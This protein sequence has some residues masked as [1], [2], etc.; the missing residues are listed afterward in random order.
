MGLLN[1][2]LDSDHFHIYRKEIKRLKYLKEAKNKSEIDR[3]ADDGEKTGVFTGSYAV[4]PFSNKK[5]QIWI[6]DYVIGSYGTGAIMAVPG[7]DLRDFEF[8]TKYNLPIVEVVSED[9]TINGRGECFTDYG[10]SVNS[11]QYN[12]LKSAELIKI[13]SKEL[14]QMG[15]GKPT[16]Q[17]RLHDWLISRQRYWGSPIPIIHCQD[18]GPIPVPEKDLPVL[19]P[20]DIEFSSTYGEDISPLATVNS[21]INTLCPEC[22]NS[23]KRDC[24]TMDTFVCSSWYYLRYPNAKYNDGPFDPK[25]LEWLPVDTYVGGA[26]HATMHLL[27][28][29]FIT[30]VLRDLG[31]LYFDEPFLK[32]YHQ[33]TIT[34]DGAKMSKSKGN[35]V[36]PDEFI[37]QYGS[38]TFRAYLMF[39]GPFDEGGDWND[40]GI[41]GIYRFLNKVW[42]VCLQTSSNSTLSDLDEKKMHK[43]I[44]VV[45]NDLKQMKF[46]TSI[47]RLMEFV[48]YYSN[49][50]D[51]SKEVK[52]TLV[53]LLAPIA[54]HISEEIWSQLGNKVSVFDENW[55]TFDDAKTID[56]V[57]TVIIQ[58]NG[59]LRG[60]LEVSD[61]INKDELI[62]QAKSV[63]NVSIHLSDKQ[64]VKEIVVPKKLVNFVV[65]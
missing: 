44:K 51:I 45:T 59:K 27:Y 64:I 58:V 21:F 7:S 19:L 57:L 31:Y 16:V 53:K 6:A 43:L 33:G 60:K 56:D 42:R 65:K 61:D 28:A 1:K 48:N 32:L 40:K 34:K 9:G 46:N 55:P 49:Q 13:I 17:Y 30:K 50:D 5:M 4:N 20:D 8:A 63:D 62:S 15:I 54:P 39:M 10:I 22:G 3:M 35:T 41:T 14:I 25:S 38:D 11:G 37:E 2:F 47:S 36:S 29:R 52:G 24:D 23:A 26:E 12:G 18:C